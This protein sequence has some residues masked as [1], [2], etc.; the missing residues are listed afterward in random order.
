MSDTAE[1]SCWGITLWAVAL[2]I[3]AIFVGSVFSNGPTTS[4]TAA[5]EV[6]GT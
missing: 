2:V 6:S 4:A 5:V 1:K 3:G